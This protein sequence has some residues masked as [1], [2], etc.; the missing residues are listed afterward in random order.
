MTVQKFS[1]EFLN[2][3]FQVNVFSEKVVIQLA[4]INFRVL[5][6]LIPTLMAQAA[7]DTGG[8]TL[9]NQRSMGMKEQSK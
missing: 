8:S 4:D 6:Q 5:S 9:V 2:L 1:G 7:P 3:L